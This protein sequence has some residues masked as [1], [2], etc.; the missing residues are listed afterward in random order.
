M[1]F[2]CR[3]SFLKYPSQTFIIGVLLLFCTQAFSQVPFGG[4]RTFDTGQGQ[5]MERGQL[6]KPKKTDERPA[7]DLYKIISYEF[8]T[9]F[10]DTSLHIR[11][12]YKLN[13]RREDNFEYLEFPNVGQPYNYLAYE[14]D[15]YP[16]LYPQMG[17][18]T[19]HQNIKQ[20][21]DIDY[22]YVPTPF[23]DLFY[24]SVVDQG[25]VLDALIAVN[26]S[27]RFNFSIGF[28][29]LRSLGNFQN[30]LTSNGLFTFTGNYK[31]A[32]GRYH[33]RFHIVAHDFLNEEN[34]GLSEQGLSDFLGDV[35]QLQ[36]PARLAVN[37]EDAESFLDVKR[38][39]LEHSYDL[40]NTQRDS[41]R[42][43]S[44][45]LGH[46]LNIQG[47]FYTFEQD[48]ADAF[49]GEAFT[50]R[51]KDRVDQNDFYNAFSATF[52]NPVFG[53]IKGKIAINNYE[54][55]FQS[56][57]QLQNDTIP[58][59]ATGTIISAGGS[60]Q[61]RLGKIS[62]IAD[63]MIN[64]SGDFEGNY[65]TGRAGYSL[66]SLSRLEARLLIQ[67]KAPDFTSQFYQSDYIN[68]NWQNN[69]SNTKTQTLG[70]SLHSSKWA[71]VDISATRIEDY[72]Y[73]ANTSG[74]LFQQLIKPFQADE[75]VTYIKIKAAKEF[76]Y[77]KWALNNTLLYQNVSQGEEI[78]RVPDFVT[79]NTFYFTDRLFNNALFLQ[80]GVTFHYFSDYFINEYNP[81]LGEFFIQNEREVGFP[82]LDIFLN[83]KVRQA[84]I[85][86]KWENINSDNEQF[87]S[88]LNPYRENIIRFGIV[89]NFFT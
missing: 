23:S 57:S 33:A 11:K 85:F 4:R 38:G 17:F 42:R 21:E 28:K 86:L 1:K 41:L 34:G 32:S 89:W 36:D 63:A 29:G 13:Y 65:L 2:A 6:R 27:P 72:L 22:Y 25:Q 76:R 61:Y 43:S 45:T 46:T 19:K 74:T 80:T 24:K 3:N 10:V 52:T 15:A 16:R 14:T 37:F 26:T 73:F 39:Y 68:F 18:T 88:P 67:S 62:L 8:D 50:Q 53:K 7:V 78:F 77:R 35:S 30:I 5:P 70:L 66:D 87:S 44:L 71:D 79:R 83:F 59:E 64:L 47:K 51:I 49:F 20:I 75:D 12:D 54:Y 82:R 55:V 60:W 9:T 69:F 40:F 56:L 58:A 48:N 31:N 81:I 84:R